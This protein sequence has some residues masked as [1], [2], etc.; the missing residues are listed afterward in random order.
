MAV[1]WLEARALAVRVQS[2]AQGIHFYKTITLPPLRSEAREAP[3]KFCQERLADDTG[4]PMV[5]TDKS[6][7][8]QDMNKGQ[9]E[10]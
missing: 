3:P 9:S 4:F 2:H 8:G 7:V 1:C 5:F 10:F 6:M